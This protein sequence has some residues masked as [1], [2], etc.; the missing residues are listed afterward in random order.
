[1]NGFVQKTIHGIKQIFSTTIESGTFREVAVEVFQ[2][3]AK[4]F[5]KY[6]NKEANS[7]SLWAGIRG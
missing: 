7:V 5:Q 2:K 6:P 4:N 3:I 1:M